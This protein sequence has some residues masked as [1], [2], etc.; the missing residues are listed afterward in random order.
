MNWSTGYSAAFLNSG[1]VRNRGVEII[2]NSK[3][4]AN[5]NFTWNTTVNWSKNENKVLS[6]AE[7]LG[8]EDNQVIG[9]GG[10]ATL[11]AKVGGSTGDIYGFGFV[12][13]SDGQI[14]PSSTTP[15][16]II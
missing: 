12:R 8:G 1:K 6:L 5:R 2:I 16:P 7:D 4:I 15:S 9:V 3:N 13:T 14:V 11:I 10:N